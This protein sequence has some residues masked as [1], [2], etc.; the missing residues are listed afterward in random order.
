MI[1]AIAGVVTGGCLG[2]LPGIVAVIMGLVALS[3]IKK[4]PDKYGGKPL[5]TAGVIIGSVSI[6]FYLVL[7]LWFL[8]PLVF[9]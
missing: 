5:A 3:Q 8:L 9:G 4:E 1:T 2:P 7:L 6:L